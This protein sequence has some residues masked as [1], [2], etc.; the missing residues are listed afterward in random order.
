MGDVFQDAMKEIFREAPPELVAGFKKKMG[1]IQDQNKHSRKTV[2]NC[3]DGLKDPPALVELLAAAYVVNG[4]LL[5]K[6]GPDP[7]EQGPSRGSKN[8]ETEEDLDYSKLL[9]EMDNLNCSVKK[10]DSVSSAEEDDVFP[11]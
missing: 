6:H 4:G 8:T 1:F 2:Q 7:P 9:E 3:L 10:P 5:F 11:H